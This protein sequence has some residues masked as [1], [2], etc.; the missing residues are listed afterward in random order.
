MTEI[1]NML[2]GLSTS[3][4]LAAI[5]LL[6][7]EL[8]SNLGETPSPDWHDDV[9]KERLANPSLEQALPLSEAMARIKE[10]VRAS[11][12]PNGSGE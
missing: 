12:N 11:K 8:E 7:S 6:W 2:S 10:R 5:D 1:Q 3:E 4:K 9:L